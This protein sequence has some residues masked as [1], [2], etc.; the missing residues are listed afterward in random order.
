MYF[1]SYVWQSQQMGHTDWRFAMKAT[2][3]HPIDWVYEAN[4]SYSRE[5]YK[6]VS[7]QKVDPDEVKYPEWWIDLE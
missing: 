7:W 5:S 4:Q 6:L 3:K 2:M 1:I